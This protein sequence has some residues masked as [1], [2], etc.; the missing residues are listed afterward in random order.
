MS[1]TENP[2]EDQLSGKV[3]RT[4][5]RPQQLLP[6]SLRWLCLVM[7]LGLMA[8][9]GVARYLTPSPAGFGTH[10][11]LGLPPCTTV[12][13]WNVPCPTCGM[14][15]SWAW[16]ARGNLIEA[17]RA[18]LGGLMLALIAIGFLPASCYFFIF[19]R[20]TPGH[21]FSQLLAISL[22]TACCVTLIQWMGRVW[23]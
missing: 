18:N 7:G 1:S 5:E 12:V 2:N 22:V 8:L 13:L 9:L 15:T 11:Q 6:S 23:L 10:Q 3:H 19:G 17:G 21:W 16:V 20:S 14:T 4:E